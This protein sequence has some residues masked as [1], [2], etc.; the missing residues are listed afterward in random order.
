MKQ[1]LNQ[2]HA[3]RVMRVAETGV[4]AVAAGYLT[5]NETDTRSLCIPFPVGGWDSQ[6][7]DD[8]HTADDIITPSRAAGIMKA[9]N[10]PGVAQLGL[11]NMAMPLSIVTEGQLHTV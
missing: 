7:A 9:A 8:N 1:M 4:C 3:R 6:G 5:M 2:V 10:Q 11:M